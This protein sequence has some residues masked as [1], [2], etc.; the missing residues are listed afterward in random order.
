ML[1][2]RCIKEN[3]AILEELVQIRNKVSL[4]VTCVTFVCAHISSYIFVNLHE[5]I[6]VF[7]TIKV[8]WLVH[9]LNFPKYIVLYFWQIEKIWCR[10][11]MKIEKN[12]P[13]S[14]MLCWRYFVLHQLFMSHT[15]SGFNFA[16]KMNCFLTE[17][18]YSWFSDT[19]CLCL[20]YAYGRNTRQGG[21]VFE[22]IVRKTATTS[23][24]RT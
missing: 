18:R 3:T 14:F 22:R 5:K 7:C 13:M 17:S 10:L 12:T 11:F 1:F 2:F 4:L 6:T 23:K 16:N 24:G 19:F 15:I 20:G 21:D 8:M 9:T